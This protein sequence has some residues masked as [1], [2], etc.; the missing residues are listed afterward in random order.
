MLVAGR[1]PC[2]RLLGRGQRGDCEGS[3]RDD[4]RSIGYPLQTRRLLLELPMH[5]A[6]AGLQRLVQ[7]HVPALAIAM[8][9]PRKIFVDGQ[10]IGEVPN[11]GDTQKDVEAMSALMR[12]KGVHRTV[13]PDQAIFRQA[14][15]F[16]TTASYLFKKDLAGWP[17]NPMSV[18]PFVVN[19]AFAL[20]PYLKTLS[21]LYGK[22]QR[23]H[24]LLELFDE[25]PADATEAL[26]Q[27]ISKAPPTAAGKDLVAF[28]AEIE[29]VRHAFVEWRYLHERTRAG[30][31]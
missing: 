27:E 19:S 28:R 22:E 23:G 10:F 20:E 17:R 6:F 9:E 13:T 30:K 3:V 14:V 12:A 1:F 15:S 16:A 31:R 18:V 8:T 24:D 7:F 26:R 29:R 25:L 11:T 5:D 21:L 2:L 4:A